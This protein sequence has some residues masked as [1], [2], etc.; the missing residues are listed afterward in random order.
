VLDDEY[1]VED[2]VPH[3]APPPAP[4]PALAAE[5]A[6]PSEPAEPVA[7]DVPHEPVQVAALPTRPATADETRVASALY[8]QGWTL[9]RD[10]DFR[11]AL[12]AFTR[13]IDVRPGFGDA[14][15]GRAWVNDRLDRLDAAVSDYGLTLQLDPNFAPA[16]AN[17]GVA[18]LYQ[19]DLAD[20][21]AD[22]ARALEL[23]D[24]EMR[25]YAVLWRYLARERDGR[26]GGGQLLGDTQDLDLGPWPGVIARYFLGEVTTEQVLSDAQASGP[27]ERRERLC[28]AYFFLGQ[29]Q[30]LA[31]DTVRA[32]DYFRKAT[33]T[34]VTAFVQY[35]A[36]HREL[37]R[38]QNR[39]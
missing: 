28:V 9:E 30:L 20:A 25:R 17:R 7:D 38:L 13:A 4:E 33:E 11:A 15:F 35:T 16:H 19:D 27:M 37:R 14:Y 31:G 5:T 2:T 29:K 23:G 39:N 12:D 34:D 24:N 26:M 3:L 32:K 8:E 1:M 21:E 22:F 18:R 36:S 10:G 6:L